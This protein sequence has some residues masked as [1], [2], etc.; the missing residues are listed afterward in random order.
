MIF[1]GPP[2]LHLTLH[3]GQQPGIW[4]QKALGD[5]KPAY[6][7]IFVDQLWS[8]GLIAR[9]GSVVQGTRLVVDAVRYGNICPQN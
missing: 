4:Q 3:L 2:A 8:T 1:D 6:C 7:T 9:S 5:Q